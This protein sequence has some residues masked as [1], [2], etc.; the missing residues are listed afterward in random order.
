MVFSNGHDIHPKAMKRK[1]LISEPKSIDAAYYKTMFLSMGWEADVVHDS[2]A[3]ASKF[4]TDSYEAVFISD[5]GKDKSK[6]FEATKH[7]RRQEK[8]SKKHIKIFGITPLA[9]DPSSKIL[10]DAGMDEVVSQPV[11]KKTLFGL[12]KISK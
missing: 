2:A 8:K 6:S 12:L 1:V 7:I 5:E 4:D 11:Y 10:K 3:V 9:H